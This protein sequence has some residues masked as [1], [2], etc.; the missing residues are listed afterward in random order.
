M[1][2]GDPFQFL[3]TPIVTDIVEERDGNVDLAKVNIDNNQ[4]LAIQYGVARGS[5][6]STERR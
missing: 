2:N 5:L 3:L 4:E 6:E 1:F